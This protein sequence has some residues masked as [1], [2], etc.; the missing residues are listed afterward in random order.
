[1]KNYIENIEMATYFQAAESYSILVWANGKK[2]MKARPIKYY[3]ASFEAQGW[4]RIHRSYMVNPHYIQN[5][6]ENRN[7]LCLQDGTILPIARRKQKAV[8]K[9]R[10]SIN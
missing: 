3:A 6:T 4:F 8:L 5:I 1:M 9:W 7:R 2:I 10:N